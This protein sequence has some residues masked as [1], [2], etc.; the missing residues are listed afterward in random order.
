MNQ[1]IPKYK[2]IEILNLL[3]I[4][5]KDIG[6]EWIKCQCPFPGHLDKHPSAGV[7]I[8]T[9]VFNCFSCTES[10]HIVTL[11]MELLNC[12]YKTAKNMVYED[13]ENVSLPPTLNLNTPIFERKVE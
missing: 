13:I 6:R 9:G 10:K 8:N 1:Q 7:N 11:L 4:K 12:D 5:Y 2:I 3:N